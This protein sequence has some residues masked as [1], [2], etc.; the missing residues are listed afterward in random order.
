MSL[1]FTTPGTYT[2]KIREVRGDDPGINYDSHTET[3]TIEVVGNNGTL[4]ATSS[5][6]S[7][8]PAFT[9]ST[10]PGTLKISK[11]TDG[12]GTGDEEFTF[13]VTLTNEYGQSLDFVSVFKETNGD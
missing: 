5:L 11:T 4:V 9:N 7:D 10:K 12:K 6:G 2:Y 13:E 8:I 1:S 3:V